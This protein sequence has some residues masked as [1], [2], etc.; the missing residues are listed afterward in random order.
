M[1]RIAVIKSNYTPY[2]GGEKY[3]KAV[4][5]AFIERGFEVDVLT[6][7]DEDWVEKGVRKVCIPMAKYNNFLRLYTF[8]RNC[9]SYLKKNFYKY[10]VVLDMDRTVLSTHIRAG[11]GSHKGWLY[12][13]SQFSPFLKN[14]SFKVNPFHNYM[15]LLE[16]KS[17][18]NPSLRALICN[19][20]M[21]KN[22]FIKYYNFDSKKI[23]VV[24]NGV[25]WN[26]FEDPFHYSLKNKEVIRKKIGL[27]NRFWLLYVG[28][29]YERKGLSFI[30]NA[31]AKMKSDYCLAVVGKD[32]NE[33][34]YKKMAISKGL[35]DRIKFFGP[36]KEV[37]KFL[38]SADAFILPTIYDPFSNA[39]LEALAMGLFTITSNANGCSEVITER[40]GYVIKDLKKEEELIY[41]I[42]LA[43]RSY[44]R[45]FIR[46]SVR[47]Y[48]FKNKLDELIDIC[49]KT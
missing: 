12:R 25:E 37:I 1:D 34:Y 16:K 38:Q 26:K 47:E 27:D 8:N 43:N 23:F 10:K 32:R 6:S 24:H 3:A 19:S 36:Q 5:N 46:N 21:V 7:S 9:Y 44:D 20:H 31:L 30:I 35:G 17:L 40:A 49:I 4:I 13:R 14:L 18:E 29:G 11:G 2:G 28:S 39:T 42:E 48:D 41:A 33:K 22:E 15:L 45:I